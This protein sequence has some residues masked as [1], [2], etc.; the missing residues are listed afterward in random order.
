MDLK[1]RPVAGILLSQTSQVWGLSREVLRM[2]VTV[3]FVAIAAI[4]LL[5]AWLNRAFILGPVRTLGDYLNSRGQ[6]RQLRDYAAIPEMYLLN[7]DATIL[8][9]I[10]GM[11]RRIAEDAAQ[12]QRDRLSTRLALESSMAGTWEYDRQQDRLRCDAQTLGLL[13]AEAD[14][15]P[16]SREQLEQWLH[17]EE[18][19]PFSGLFTRSRDDGERGFQMEC[20]IRHGAGGYRWYL[21]KGDSLEWD[22][23]GNGVLFSGIL[24]DIDAKKRME[25]EL[26][27]LSYHD[28][29]TGLYN[30]RY[31]EEQLLALDQPGCLPT[32]IF[33]AD[34]NGLKLANDTFGHERGDQLLRQAAESLR[35]AVGPEA[36][37]SRWG[38]D[39]FAVL[40][41]HTDE[42]QAEAVLERIK[43]RCRDR[44]AQGLGLHLAVGHA[45]KK[46]GALTLQHLVHAAE[47]SMYRDK[48]LESR[49]AHADFLARFR[50]QLHEKGIE[51]FEHCQRAAALGLALGSQL[52]LSEE[53]LEEIEQMSHLHDIGKIAMPESLFAKPGPLTEMEWALMRNHPEIGFRIVALMQDYAHLAQ[54]ILSHHEWYDGSGYPRGL[55]GR[56]IP[57]AARILALAE[58]VTVMRE[59]ASYKGPMALPEVV[60]ELR[61]CQGTQF[62]PELTDLMV[63]ILETE[64]TAPAE[65]GIMGGQASTTQSEE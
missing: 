18:Q 17:P 34:I 45:V 15:F 23:A 5:Q 14:A 2:V 46:S 60:L 44:E 3:T 32:A 13:G 6:D 1:G 37:V 30:R 8:G 12:L 22:E 25:S 39:E 26:R 56:E 33:V 40:L 35:E 24:L 41:P 9:R 7:E 11:L 29:L 42:T 50:L 57:L 61:R 62:D 58:A 16:M 64:H 28:K 53:L 55:K 43:A 63:G 49:G 4:T 27:Y 51:T 31:F 36:V 20:R 10:H 54:S 65:R 52:G 38:G 21:L 47:E 19:E 59:G 48:M